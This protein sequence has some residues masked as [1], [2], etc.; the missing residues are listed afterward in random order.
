MIP[1]RIANLTK[2]YGDRLALDDL[3][4]DV[5]PGAVFGLLGRNGAG[6]STAIACVL[7]LISKTAGDVKVFGEPL[8]ARTFD[9]IAYVPE[10]DALEGWM[11]TR[12]HAEFRRRC[13]SRFDRT[14]MNDLIERF[15]IEPGRPLRK[16][17]K[18]Q[19]QGVALAL[20]F[21]QRPDLMILD[22][23]AAGL[24]PVMQRRILDTIVSAAADGATILFS[25]HHIG[26]VEQAA[27]RVG[28]LDRGKLVLEADVDHLRATR[29]VVEAVF[30]DGHL[31]QRY[32]NGDVALIEAQLRARSPVS[33]S[34]RAL[35][36]EQI[37]LA[38]IGETKERHE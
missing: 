18:G 33:V 16:L 9:R 31:E 14:L 15:E 32:A 35:H 7:G 3:S 4:L 2:R 12:E 11:T 1:L 34:R 19:R 38:T 28:V 17:S 21:A 27:E 8:H 23:P 25:S 30:D 6:K 13:F 26:H 24:D 37:F 29:F 36:L 22:E 10:I 5:K 20:A